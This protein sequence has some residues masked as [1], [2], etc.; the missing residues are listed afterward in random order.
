MNIQALPAQSNSAPHLAGGKA[1]HYM[2]STN[3]KFL[4]N[5]HHNV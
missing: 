2:K 4:S 5:Q 3:E 1:V